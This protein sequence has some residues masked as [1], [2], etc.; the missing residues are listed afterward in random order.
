[1][2]AGNESIALAGGCAARSTAAA[3]DQLAIEFDIEILLLAFQGRQKLGLGHVITLGLA[4]TDRREPG[5]MRGHRGCMDGSSSN[6]RQTEQGNG[7]SAAAT[8]TE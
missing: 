5:R 8:L 4:M 2:P 3:D 7:A 1:V 6:R